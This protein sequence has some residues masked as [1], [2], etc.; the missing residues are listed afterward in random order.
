MTP[1]SSTIDQQS[2][3]ETPWTIDDAQDSDH[4]WVQVEVSIPQNV[5]NGLYYGSLNFEYDG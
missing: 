5:E 1:K 3:L 4:V 2:T